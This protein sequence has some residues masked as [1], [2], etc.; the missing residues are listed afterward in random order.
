MCALKRQ[1]D[2]TSRVGTHNSHHDSP[3]G[4][5]RFKIWEAARATSAAPLCF[6][7]VEVGGEKYWDGAMSDNN[8]ILQ[9]W[10][11]KEDR[12]HLGA[13]SVSCVIS[14]GTGSIIHSP[15]NSNESEGTSKILRATAEMLTNTELKHQEFEEITRKENIN[16]HRLNPEI[17]L[18]KVDLADF[19]KLDLL[20][21]Y[22][23]EYLQ[24]PEVRQEV[25]DCAA[26]LLPPLPVVKSPARPLVK[27]EVNRSMTGILVGRLRPGTSK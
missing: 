24:R 19:A 13:P 5:K 18:G 23:R 2:V 21:Q 25:K 12:H 20:E 10:K 9:V 4:L 17:G 16:Y 14:L 1:E 27:P 26:A 7:E 22:T 6:E 3:P 8:P 15:H 11:E